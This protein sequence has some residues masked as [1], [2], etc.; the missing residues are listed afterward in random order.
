[1]RLS[2]Q[3]SISG[4]QRRSQAGDSLWALDERARLSKSDK[5]DGFQ[6]QRVRLRARGKEVRYFFSM[7]KSTDG[8]HRVNARGVYAASAHMRPLC[9]PTWALK[10]TGLSCVNLQAP[11]LMSFVFHDLHLWRCGFVVFNPNSS[12]S[13][14]KAFKSGCV[15]WCVNHGPFCTFPFRHLLCSCSYMMVVLMIWHTLAFCDPPVCSALL[16]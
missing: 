7:G 13:S 12:S 3:M 16:N 2:A 14:R 6:D 11:E 5:S 9:G 15:I 1:M 4:C 10:D 8:K